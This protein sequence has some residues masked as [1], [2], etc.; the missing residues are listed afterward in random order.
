MSWGEHQVVT[1]LEP[2]PSGTNIGNLEWRR[3]HS[4]YWAQV[5]LSRKGPSEWK[6]ILNTWTWQCQYVCQVLHTSKGDPCHRFKTTNT[7]NCL[8][9]L[10]TLLVTLFYSYVLYINEITLHPCKTFPT[11]IHLYRSL[12]TC[13][14][15][16][17]L[18]PRLPGWDWEGCVSRQL[19]QHNNT[20]HFS[21]S[22]LTDA[23]LGRSLN[24][25][26]V[27]NVIGI[28]D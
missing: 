21:T 28:S 12:V 23:H 10:Y 1:R 14:V 7:F 27:F 17:L 15:M 16:S 25:S 24:S 20:L 26:V 2:G 19:F 22:R 13:N 5:N 18:L 9:W 8:S 3:Q 11:N 4:F 6:V